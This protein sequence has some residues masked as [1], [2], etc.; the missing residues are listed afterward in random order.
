MTKCRNLTV[1]WQ[2]QDRNVLG[3][4]RRVC[5]F[6]KDPK[7]GKTLSRFLSSVGGWCQID[8]STCNTTL[9]YKSRRIQTTYP[10]APDAHRPL[11]L[12]LVTS[13]LSDTLYGNR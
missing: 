5:D 1:R 6:N 4:V 7:K 9:T 12:F 11:E 3:L 13:D 2:L 8:P 10:V